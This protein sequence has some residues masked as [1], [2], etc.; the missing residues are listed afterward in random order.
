MKHAHMICLAILAVAIAHGCSPKPTVSPLS[1]NEAAENKDVLTTGKPFQFTIT[2]DFAM[3]KKESDADGSNE[4]DEMVAI[5]IAINKMDGQYPVLYDLDCE[6]DGEY[7]FT[8]LTEDH[9][10]V[11]GRNSGTHQ[12]SI[13]GAVPA[14]FLCEKPREDC[15]AT[16]DRD[17]QCF[18]FTGME[19]ALQSIDSWGDIA[20][21]SMH[22]FAAN[23]HNLNAIPAQAPDLRLVR[24]MSEMFAKAYSFNQPI[25]HWDVSGVTNMSRLFMKSHS[26]NQPLEQWDVFHVTNMS[27]MFAWA[28]SF[29][30]PLESWNV[31]N[32]TDMSGM[33]AWATSFNQPLERWDVSHVTNMSWIFTGAASFNQPLAKWNVANVTDMHGSFSWAISYQQPLENWN[34]ANVTNMRGMFWGAQA[35]NQPLENWNVASVTDMSVMFHGATSFNQPLAKW[36]VSH[37]TD[38]SGM[39]LGAAAFN[40]PLEKWDVS[41]VTDTSGMFKDAT[42]FNQP[43]EKWN[44]ANVTNMSGMFSGASAF[45]QPL[46][47]WNVSNVTDMNAMFNGATS[48]NQP[49]EGWDVSNVTNMYAMFMGATSFNQ[50]LEAWDV[51]NAT[52][53]GAMFMDATSFHQPLERWK[54]LY[55]EFCYHPIRCVGAACWDKIEIYKSPDKR[56]VQ[57]VVRQH[58]DEL[59]ACYEKGLEKDHNLSGRVHMGWI[60][61]PQGLVTKVLVMKSTLNNKPV[62]DCIQNVILHWRFPQA[63]SSC[64]RDWNGFL[65][66]EYPFLFEPRQ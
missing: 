20:W 42:S 31:Y 61:S 12:I 51:T 60:I 53:R 8:G 47:S 29:N 10:C 3:D 65:F 56:S 28:T 44:V 14:L 33:F 7:E 39:F 62:E 63:V 49:L 15:N 25:A 55:P 38:M 40:Q 58:F 5:E 13:R 59:R 54:T 4:Q 66:V 11:Y 22:A 46:E 1:A 36:N 64:G 52:Y 17:S 35:F 21:K 6:S 48:F 57:R 16:K 50:P 41:N 34:V 30:Q 45:N 2:T 18:S 32:V 43:L 37:V 23:C 26:F 27:N 19:N 9:T 24:D